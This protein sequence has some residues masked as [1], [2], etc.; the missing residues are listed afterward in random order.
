MD[1]GVG[2]TVLINVRAGI[3]LKHDTRNHVCAIWKCGLDPTAAAGAESGDPG[4]FGELPPPFGNRGITRLTSR[5]PD[6]K[7]VPYI[8]AILQRIEYPTETFTRGARHRV[9]D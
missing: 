1:P 3:D 2:W 9:Q 4:K 6:P 8:F 5:C 7:L